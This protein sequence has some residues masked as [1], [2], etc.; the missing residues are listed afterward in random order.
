MAASFNQDLL[1][2]VAQVTAEEARAKY[3][4]FVKYEDRSIY[5]GLTFWTP[6]YQHFRDPG[7]AGGQETYGEDPTLRAAWVAFI[8]G[9]QGDHPRYLKRRPVR[10]TMLSTAAQNQSDMNLMLLSTKRPEET[11]LPAF[12][13][14][15]KEAKVGGSDGAYNR[16]NGHPA[17][18]HPKL[19]TEILRE[20][21]GFEGHVVSDCGAISDFH[22]HHR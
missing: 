10:S 9:L 3:N 13:D 1:H 22:L 11:Y 21:W 20:E 18:A 4:M 15:V 6:Q 8:K 19:L 2:R 7:G 12:R 5:K 17:C 14:A 16:V